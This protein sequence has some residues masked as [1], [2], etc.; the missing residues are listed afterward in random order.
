MANAEESGLGPNPL[1]DKDLA[2]SGH[3]TDRE[4]LNFEK[5]QLL[6]LYNAHSLLTCE[7]MNC[8]Q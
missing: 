2:G 4:H 7:Y 3:M 5:L 6:L 1:M 8:E